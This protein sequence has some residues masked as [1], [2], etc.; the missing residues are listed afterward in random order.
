MKYASFVSLRLRINRNM[1]HDIYPGIDCGNLFNFSLRRHYKKMHFT[2][3]GM[4][5][6][7]LLTLL[8][9]QALQMEI[10]LWTFKED[11]HITFEI[12]E[13]KEKS[14]TWVLE[15]VLLNI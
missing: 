11:A 3:S 13:G 12:S 7:H 1:H 15:L 2:T 6:W 14:N 9:K 8:C 4:T 5:S 10:N